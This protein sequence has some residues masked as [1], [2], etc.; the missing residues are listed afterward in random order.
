MTAPDSYC[1]EVEAYLCRRNQGH[2]IRIVGPAFE[3]VSGWS[4]KGIPISVVC[5]GIDRTVERH[6][7]KGPR[8]RPVRIEFCEADVLDAF[9][10]WRRAVGVA[11]LN[12]QV[13]EEGEGQARGGRRRP[14][15]MAHLDRVLARLT[16]LRG[17]ERQPAALAASL[18]EFVRAL[19]RLRA[20][21][22]QARGEARATLIAELAALDRALMDQAMAALDPAGRAAAE[23]DVRDALASYR[24]RM[25]PEAYQKASTAATERHVRDNLGLPVLAYDTE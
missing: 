12:I 15:L 16:T 22:P 5:A 23:R 3:L 14:T 11:G 8:R 18:E 4:D 6:D 24:D 10:A 25:P 21:A 17:S 1:R 20:I 2:L 9:D 13:A 19:D 7:K